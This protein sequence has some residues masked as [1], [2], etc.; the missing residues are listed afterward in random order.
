MK[1]NRKGLGR[2]RKEDIRGYKQITTGQLLVI[3]VM[4]PW[5]LVILFLRI[6]EQNPNIQHI[7]PTV[8]IVHLEKILNYGL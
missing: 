7:K 5:G 3:K 4:Q 2:T 1:D 6:T 8:Y